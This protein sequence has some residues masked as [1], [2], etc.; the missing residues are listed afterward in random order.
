MSG[1]SGR[2]VMRAGFAGL[3]FCA[4]VAGCKSGSAPPSDSDRSAVKAML[5]KADAFDGA[6]DS[7]VSK[8]ASCALGMDGKAEH[9]LAVEGVT[10]RFCSDDCLKSFGKDTTQSVLAMKIPAK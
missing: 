6:T 5:A 4:A 1:T 3:L 9:T 2:S 10:M 8:C 7:V